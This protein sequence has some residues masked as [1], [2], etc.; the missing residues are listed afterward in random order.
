MSRIN[1]TRVVRVLSDA[2]AMGDEAAAAK[3]KISTKTVERYRKRAAEQPEL[4]A[5]V[6]ENHRRIEKTLSQMRVEFMRDALASMLTKLE[7]ATLYEVAGAMKIVGDLHQVAL[8]VAAEENG[9]ERSC[10]A[11]SKAAE[12]AGS[13][14]SAQAAH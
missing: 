7:G 4:S 13:Y 8:A 6:R 11:D 1:P 9:D 2:V 5:D 12:D 3:W 14:S 10:C